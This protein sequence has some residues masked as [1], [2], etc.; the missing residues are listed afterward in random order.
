MT[1]RET[2]VEGISLRWKTNLTDEQLREFYAKYQAEITKRIEANPA[3]GV[4]VIPLQLGY[5]EFLDGYCAWCASNE[6]H[7]VIYRS[8]HEWELWSAHN[9]EVEELRREQALETAVEVKL[10]LTEDEHLKERMEA[11]IAIKDYATAAAYLNARAEIRRRNK[12]RVIMPI[13]WT[14]WYPDQVLARFPESR[15]GIEFYKCYNPILQ[16]FTNFAHWFSVGCHPQDEKRISETKAIYDA[17]MEMFPN[18][19]FVAQCAS[20]FFRRVKRYELAIQICTNAI[21]RG[22]KDGTKSGFSGRIS[23]LKREMEK[24]SAQDRGELEGRRSQSR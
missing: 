20:L 22:L 23:R 5:F 21:S 3:K 11:A 7:N 18:D 8:N 14:H 19:G 13:Q 9:A 17:A 24:E 1:L 2:V 6:I 16:F 15:Y 12:V 10:L 4:F